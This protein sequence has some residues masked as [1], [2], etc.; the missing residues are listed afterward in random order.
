MFTAGQKLLIVVPILNSSCASYTAC[1]G[2]LEYR[3]NIRPRMKHNSRKEQS[4]ASFVT[5]VVIQQY[6]EVDWTF[7]HS[8]AKQPSGAQ[9]SCYAP[10]PDPEIHSSISDIPPLMRMSSLRD[11]AKRTGRPVLCAATAAA[12]ATGT[13]LATFP[14]KAPPIRRHTAVRQQRFCLDP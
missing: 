7:L 1:S 2:M 3:C 11:R 13:L 10:K 14:P 4:W 6:G 8:S 5:G 9:T 12:A